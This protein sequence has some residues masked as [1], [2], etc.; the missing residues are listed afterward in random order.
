MQCKNQ[1]RYRFIILF[2]HIH[3]IGIYVCLFWVYIHRKYLEKS[4][5]GDY[6]Y[7]MGAYF[8]TSIF[9]MFYNEYS[10]P[11]IRKILILNRKQNKSLFC[12]F[13]KTLGI[14]CYFYNLLIKLRF[15]LSCFTENNLVTRK[16]EYQRGQ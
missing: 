14:I 9:W 13:Y 5:T 2:T 16:Q 12:T 8:Y 1:F 3:T 7:M 15:F 6:L 10:F 4:V 11:I